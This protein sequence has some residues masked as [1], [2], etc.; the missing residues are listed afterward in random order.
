MAAQD[1][2]FLPVPLDPSPV[3]TGYFTSRPT[4]K[5]FIRRGGEFLRAAQSLAAV[6]SL[7]GVVHA[8][9]AETS[10]PW[11]LFRPLAEAV[12]VAQHHDAVSG[13]AK[14][15]VT[16]DYA[17]R[18]QRGIDGVEGHFSR[19]L[20]AA[21]L[22]RG[23][24]SAPAP[25]SPDP[26]AVAT[27][28]PLL[29]VSACPVTE[30]MTPG[31]VVAVLAYNPLAWERIEHVRIP[32]NAAAARRAVVVDASS[33]EFRAVRHVARAAPP[34]PLAGRTTTQLVFSSLRSRRSPSP[35]FSCSL[36]ENEVLPETALAEAAEETGASESDANDGE[37]VSV[38]LDPND[39]SLLVDFV[40]DADVQP[41]RKVTAAFYAGSRRKRRF[42]PQRSVRVQ[43]RLVPKGDAARARRRLTPARPE[44]SAPGFSPGDSRGVWGLGERRG[45]DVVD[46]AGS[47]RRG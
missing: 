31:D 22:T 13:T 2:R 25:P 18:I 40:V 45:E 20:N 12:A 3:L 32:M 1:W 21:L 41:P 36:S 46:R 14:Q 34:A 11:D 6:V 9:G 4:L 33:G 27:R 42:R 26:D 24:P 47:S 37:A 23:S 16:N 39:G 29:N 35:P 15:H 5:A 17:V 38:S 28:C 44:C 19:T 7:R 10:T 30:S 43:T 8:P